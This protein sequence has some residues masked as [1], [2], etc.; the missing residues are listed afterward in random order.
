MK[1]ER[2]LAFL[3]NISVNSNMKATLK[4]YIMCIFKGEPII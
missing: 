2:N 3:K 4:S 1:P